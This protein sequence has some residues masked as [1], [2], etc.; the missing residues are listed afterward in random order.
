MF[1]LVYYVQTIHTIDKSN[2]LWMYIYVCHRDALPDAIEANT[3]LWTTFFCFICTAAILN[4]YQMAT[5]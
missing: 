2:M 1:F 5:A 4:L 3:S